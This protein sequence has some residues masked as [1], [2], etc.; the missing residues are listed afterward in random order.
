M[1]M[2]IFD[3]NSAAHLLELVG[4]YVSNIE[5][6]AGYIRSYQGFE[7]N[8]IMSDL[9]EK[10]E[11]EPDPSRRTDLRILRNAFEKLQ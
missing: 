9:D 3:E 10:I 11:R 8:E 5:Y 6:V 1:I 2:V 7:K 4:P